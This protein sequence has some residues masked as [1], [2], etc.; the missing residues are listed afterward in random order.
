[1][2]VKKTVSNKKQIMKKETTKVGGLSAE[3]YSAK[4]RSLGKI[5]LPKEIFGVKINDQLLAQAV[6]VFLANQRQ[7]NASTKTRGMV[8]GSSR[9]IYRQKGTGRARHGSIRAPIFVKGGIAFGPKP[10]DFSL[11]FP[12]KM[13]KAALFSALSSKQ[14]S[15]EIKVISDLTKIEPKTKNIAGLLKT[16]NK[17]KKKTKNLLVLAT[18]DSGSAR[19]A[20]RNIEKLNIIVGS[21]L[22]AYDVLSNTQILFMKEAIDDIKQTFLGGNK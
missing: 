4:G 9:K 19:I 20:G 11:K 1:M 17:D 22:N 16:L 14:K 15:G 8:Q 10:H 3:M 13:K 2:P 5:A 21:N 18:K 7:G 6:R 12:K